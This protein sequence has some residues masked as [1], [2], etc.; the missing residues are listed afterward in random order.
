MQTTIQYIKKELNGLYPESEIEGFS[1]LIVEEVLGWNYT[2][3][4][5]NRN[6]SLENADFEKICQIV[7][8]LKTFEPL[9]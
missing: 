8:R 7:E 1:K 3:Q 9:Q 2:Q 5:L 6:T 4:V